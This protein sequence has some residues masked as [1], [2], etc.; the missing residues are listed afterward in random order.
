MK[1]INEI[2]VTEDD[3]AT[4]LRGMAVMKI[5]DC[6]IAD[7]ESQHLSNANAVL[8]ASEAL[9]TVA[10][11]YVGNHT[12]AETIE[13]IVFADKLQIVCF[14]L[15][16]GRLAYIDKEFAPAEEKVINAIAK[17][18]GITE[19]ELCSIK[20]EIKREY[21]FYLQRQVLLENLLK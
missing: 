4:F 10:K 21:E 3:K 8:R 19:D 7:E 14:L 5:S 11:D 17:R 16:A 13:S 2:F 15:E 1:H 20:E 6:K 12:Q 9:V 18:N